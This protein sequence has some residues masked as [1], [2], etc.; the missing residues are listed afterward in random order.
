V[1][2]INQDHPVYAN[3]SRKTD[4]HVMHLTRLLA[5]ELALL[6]DSASPREAFASQTQ[7]LRDAY[8]SEEA[9]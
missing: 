7:I 1:I 9:D 4:P 2:Y 3:A 5:Q 8:P 6:A